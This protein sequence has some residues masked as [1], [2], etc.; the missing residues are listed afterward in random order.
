[1]VIKY[2]FDLTTVLLGS[3]RT[4]DV[5]H[6]RLLTHLRILKSS[7]KNFF[8]LNIAKIRFIVYL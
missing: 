7:K 4:F 5:T 6:S 2:I 3:L 1:M 8:F